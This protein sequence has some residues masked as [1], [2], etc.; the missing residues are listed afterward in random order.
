MNTLLSQMS[1]SISCKNI[2]ELEKNRYISN[3]SIYETNFNIKMSYP[4]LDEI[5][6][7]ESINN[8]LM[9]GIK[10]DKKNCLYKRP[11]YKDGEWIYQFDNRNIEPKFN[12][13]TRKR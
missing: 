12:I 1:D 4:S 2:Q 8:N 7:N 13:Q 6:N 10:I 11:I 9:R 3:D 5:E